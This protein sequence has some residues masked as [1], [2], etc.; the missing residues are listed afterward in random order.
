LS[1]RGIFFAPAVAD[2]AGNGAGTIFTVVRGA[3]T[4]DKSL[5]ALD[6]K[7]RQLDAVSVP[8]GGGASPVLCRFAGRSDVSLLALSGGGQLLCYRPEQVAS[9]V[10]ILWP[11]IRNDLANSGFIQ[12]NKPHP[13]KKPTTAAKP[14]IVATKRQALAGSNSLTLPG[15]IPKAQLLSLKVVSPDKSAHVELIRWS[16]GANPT[17]VTFDTHVPGNYE[18]TLQ[19]HDT[20]RNTVVQSEHYAY[21]LDPD[22]ETDAT[23]LAEVVAELERLG[24]EAP[25]TSA[26]AFLRSG[27]SSFRASAANKKHFRLRRIAATL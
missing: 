13:Q 5:Y 14:N 21:C 10:T 4:D 18:V 26:L 16:P 9:G 6:A 15:D 19:W 27:F 17:N 24:R 2:L 25:A 7:G 1:G 11:G 22:Y 20:K 12:S 8:G 23:R 3:G